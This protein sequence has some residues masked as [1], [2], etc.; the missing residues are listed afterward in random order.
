MRGRGTW[1]RGPCARRTRLP[2][3]TH[4]S[5][6]V[7]RHDGEARLSRG[8]GAASPCAGREAH[9]GT[10]AAGRAWTAAT[11]GR[12]GD[13]VPHPVCNN[14]AALSKTYTYFFL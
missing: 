12:D 10:Y 11:G 6:L 1:E 13:H 3:G 5:S 9:P 2:K 8:R 7:N 4:A 14:C